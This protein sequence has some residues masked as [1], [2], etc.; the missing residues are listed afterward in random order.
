MGIKEVCG[1][2]KTKAK[3]ITNKDILIA[4][5][6]RYFHC[7]IYLH[8]METYWVDGEIYILSCGTCGK[9]YYSDNTSEVDKSFLEFIKN[10]RKRRNKE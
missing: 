8:Q 6:R 1:K 2:M 4:R 10:K 3:E 7:L 9:I 5:I